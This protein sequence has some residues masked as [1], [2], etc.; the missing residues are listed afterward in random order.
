MV[1]A[2]NSFTNFFP[3]L[4]HLTEETFKEEL[5]GDNPLGHN[6]AIAKAYASLIHSIYTGNQSFA[7]RV[8]KGTLGRCQP[9]FSSYGQQ[10]SQEFLSFLIDGLHEDLNRIQKKPY[11]ENPE[12]DDKTV[13]DPQAIRQLGEQFRENHEKR[14]DSVAM[15]LFSGFYKNTMV[16]PDCEKVSVTF[17]PYAQVTLQLPIEHPWQHKIH[18]FPLHDRPV[19]IDV[20]ID[21]ASTIRGLKEYVARRISKAKPENLVIAEEYQKRFYKVFENAEMLSD[22]GIG[23][24]DKI[25]VYELDDSPTNWPPLDKKKFKKSFNLFGNSNDTPVPEMSSNAAERMAVPVLSRF[26]QGNPRAGHILSPFFILVTREEAKDSESVFRKVMQKVETMTTRPLFEDEDSPTIEDKVSVNDGKNIDDGTASDDT[27]VQARSVEG[28]DELVDVTM[29]NG[30]SETKAEDGPSICRRPR[31]RV[32]DLSCFVDAGIRASF[33]MCFQS[34]HNELI[35]TNLTSVSDSAKLQLLSSR[36]PQRP[37]RKLSSSSLAS[38]GSGKWKDEG[39]QSSDDEL[40]DGD[41]SLNDSAAPVSADESDDNSRNSR[42]W[43]GK[44]K[45]R[46][47][48]PRFM[49]GKGNIF[50]RSKSRGEQKED[51][52]LRLGESLILDW[53]ADGYDQLF[54]GSNADDM[55]G[56][57]SDE[58]QL[59][60]PDP[61]LEAR[62][63]KRNA[64]KKAGI[65]LDECFAES[66]KSEVLSEDNAWYCSRCKEL[67]RAT[68]TL[69]MWTVPDILVVHLKRF[70][71]G[72]RLSLRDKIEALVDFPVTGLDLSGKVGLPEDKSLA[73]DLFAVDNHFG[74]IGGG[75]YTANV[76]NFVDGN[77]Y[78]Y[79]GKST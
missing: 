44:S 71:S 76:K 30:V 66:S 78:E 73:Y 35:P 22:A 39:S 23:E 24:S 65:T 41:G 31:S 12:S 19:V 28:D 69:E 8:F 1:R 38:R 62:R 3:L 2:H 51:Y 7:P 55:R 17:D 50:R 27:R 48:G 4:T 52:L 13:H 5:N 42:T 15:D 40:A 36:E 25:C 64:R 20:D 53:Y 18:F 10:D 70:S 57:P 56:Q 74:G 29:T 59:K 75:H 16:C 33:D 79:N 32:L 43:T 63:Q 45:T 21:K 14:N 67:R 49:R 60:L 68:K 47:L 34:G 37:S 26:K 9:L 58:H 54:G 72:G 77:W 11:I 6:G 46:R 61:E